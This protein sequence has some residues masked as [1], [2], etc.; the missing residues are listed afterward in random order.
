[1]VRDV[2]RTA[3]WAERVRVG[4][5]RGEETVWCERL[6][7]RVRES[8]AADKER[9]NLLRRATEIPAGFLDNPDACEAVRRAATGQKLWPLVAIGKG[10]AKTLVNGVRLDGVSIR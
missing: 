3:V 10:Q 4:I 7:E 1:R 8:H 2:C 5:L 6:R 9:A